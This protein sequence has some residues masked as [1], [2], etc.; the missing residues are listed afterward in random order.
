MGRRAIFT[1]RKIALRIRDGYGQG[2]GAD[3]KSWLKVGDFPSL[4]R[5]HRI[6]GTKVNRIF[7]FFSDL[8]Q[9]YFYHLEWL[10]NIEDIRE[11][12]PLFPVSE[13]ESIASSMKYK[14][15][16]NVGGHNSCVMTTDF[17]VGFS[18]FRANERETRKPPAMRVDE[19]SFS[20][21]KQ[22]HLAKIEK[23]P[24]TLKKQGGFDPNG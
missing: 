15:P 2:S 9:Y 1:E 21:K 17:L 22:N 6:R 16:Q 23:L 10:D 12:F 4:G 8:E 24:R 7:H 14:H 20:F 11:Q 19:R 13:T 5:C 3:Y 18:P